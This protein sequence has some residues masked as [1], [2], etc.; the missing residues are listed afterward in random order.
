[1]TSSRGLWEQKR[2]LLPIRKSSHPARHWRDCINLHKLPKACKQIFSKKAILKNSHLLT[3]LVGLNLPC[4]AHSV[5]LLLRVTLH[6]QEMGC[7]LP[8][9][10]VKDRQVIDEWQERKKDDT[11]R[12]RCMSTAQ[13]SQN[14]NSC[15]GKRILDQ[16]LKKKKSRF[17]VNLRSY[18]VT[19]KENK[20]LA[21]LDLIAHHFAWCFTEH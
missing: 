20:L 10:R 11:F 2:S 14:I 19:M 5:W 21:G 12:K 4:G 17:W 9:R 1:M 3:F 6:L 16:Q 8:S 13:T 7:Y 15:K 18:V